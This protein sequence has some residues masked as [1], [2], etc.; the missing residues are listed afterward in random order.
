MRWIE[1]F[2]KVQCRIYIGYCDGVKLPSQN[3]SLGPIFI[4]L[5]DS[6]VDLGRRVRLGLNPNLSTRAL[7]PSPETS[8]KGVGE[9]LKEMRI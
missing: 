3:C 6:N 2:D 4:S 8:L 9:W 1:S 7:W 5:G